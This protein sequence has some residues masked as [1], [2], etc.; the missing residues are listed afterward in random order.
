[1]ARKLQ[2]SNIMM[3]HELT[4]YFYRPQ[5]SSYLDVGEVEGLSNLQ[6]TFQIFPSPLIHSQK[7]SAL[8]KTSN[9]SDHGSANKP[10]VATH[11]ITVRKLPYLIFIKVGYDKHQQR[12]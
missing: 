11:Q 5:A 7:S 12:E 1:M 4:F 6:S 10:T 3:V 8:N 2:Q 9:T